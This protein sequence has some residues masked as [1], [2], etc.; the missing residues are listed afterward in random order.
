[1]S[2]KLSAIFTPVDKA[3]FPLLNVQAQALPTNVRLVRL[4]NVDLQQTINYKCKK[5][6]SISLL[7]IPRVMARLRYG[8]YR[9]K[10]A[11]FKEQKIFL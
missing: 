2:I 4:S 11:R 6:Y 9:S 10:L 7:L 5:V 8:D 3:K 1:M